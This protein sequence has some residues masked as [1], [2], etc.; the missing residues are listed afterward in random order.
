[1]VQDGKS[2]LF[3]YLEQQF[4]TGRACSCLWR[5]GPRQ[6]TG[7]RHWLLILAKVNSWVERL[8]REGHKAVG[9]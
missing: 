5:G 6:H 2:S 9:I 8:D 3:L 4:P 1:M 7:T